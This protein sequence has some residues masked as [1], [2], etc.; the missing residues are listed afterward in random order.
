MIDEAQL[1]NMV[2]GSWTTQAYTNIVEA[3]QESG[4][5]GLTKNNVKNRQ[6]SLK[7]TSC[8][9]HDLFS[10]LTGFAWNQSTKIFEAE[11]EVWDDL[12]KVYN[13]PLAF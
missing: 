10:G 9:V 3:L 13:S 5:V 2:Y 8:E 6:K 11:H 1:G 7:D 12:I 4:L